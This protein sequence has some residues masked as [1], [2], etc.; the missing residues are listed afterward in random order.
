MISFVLLISRAG[1][2]ETTKDAVYSAMNY[3]GKSFP[4]SMYTEEGT[5]IERNSSSYI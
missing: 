5:P 3:M 2:A 1:N 4:V